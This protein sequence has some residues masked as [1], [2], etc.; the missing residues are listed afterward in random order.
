MKRTQ[1][2]LLMAVIAMAMSA[3][4]SGIN[5]S[6][7]VVDG[8][9][10]DPMEYVN[11]TMR[12]VGT[13]KILGVGAVTD[14][15]GYFILKNIPEGKYILK[16]SFV[17]YTATLK[18]VI[19]GVKNIDLGTIV[20]NEDSKMLKEVEVK[21]MKSQMKFELDK[22]VFNVDQNIA[23]A[24]ASASEVLETIPSV[25]VDNDGQV[26]LRGNSSVTIWINGKPSGLSSDNR[27]QILEQ[28]PA[29]SIEKVE[30][31]TNPSAKYSPE[32]TAGII[33]IVLKQDRK[34]GYYGSAQVGGDTKGGYNVGGNINYN[35]GKWDTFLNIGVRGRKR[36]G[37]SYS[38]RDYTDGT[39]LNSWS[40]NN[41]KNNNL[42]F[43]GGVT[44]NLTKN[45]SF[46]F[47]GFGMLGSGNEDSSTKY[48]SDV[49]GSFSTGLSETNSDMNGK[50]GNVELGYNHKFREN[51]TLDFSASFNLWR[52]PNDALY[53]R[54]YVYPESTKTQYQQQNNHIKVNNWEFQADY[55]NQISKQFKIQSGYKGTLS[56]EDSPMTT[57][58]G[59]AQND[60][61][62]DADLFNRFIYDQ[63][64]QALYATFGGKINKNLN[65]QA[66]LRG[67][68]WHNEA[69]SLSYGQVASQIEPIKT[70]K[71]ALF[72]SAFLSYSLPKD[73]ELQ[74]NYTRRIQRPWGGQLNSF[75]NISDPTNISY[76]NPNLKPQFSNAFELN[77][78]KS[79]TNHILSVS[80]YYR[81]T[82]DVIQRISFMKD[83]VMN[84]TSDNVSQ[85]L[86]TGGEFVVKNKL[87]KRL[88]LTTTVNVYYNKLDGFS[89][90]PVGAEKPVTGEMQDNF[91]WNVRVMASAMLPWDLTLQLNGSYNAK[92]LVA[93][94][95]MKPMYMLG[96]G[97]KKQL[98]AWSFSLNM[99]D[100][101]DS[102]KWR[103]ITDGPT[104]HMES[105]RKGGGRRLNFTVSYSF[106][107]MRAKKPKIKKEDASTG[108]GYE[109]MGGGEE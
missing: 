4:V 81:T 13:T 1:I 62:I 2:T 100:I 66:G 88:D 76:G 52:M 71:F 60:M 53:H 18:N 67:E 103:T 31:I 96:A 75:V 7:K 5:L 58:S 11:I 30:V 45:D 37:S 20:L 104:Y 33:N 3:I 9:T 55:E 22:K 106:G 46:Y 47:S 28:L 63:N 42:F 92:Q 97:L 8:T 59:V 44:Y 73:N 95:Y 57:Y 102:R 56:Y 17:G 105:E 25:E 98:G 89:Y 12:K 49:P 99:R 85:S 10:Q 51:H 23:S 84:S 64:I 101:L 77:Y 26:S 65:F 16:S 36:D 41:R 90:M 21:G 79:W 50:G 109:D 91:T 27:A 39:F 93:Q 82:N 15:A 83:G 86:A 87:F 70:D 80:G 40:D 74:V 29:E 34:S 24:G 6:G 14:S 48:E 72:P 107:N 54:E 19:V 94:G 35:V 78:I 38:L 108:S 68:Y 69:K 61:K 43:R 32:G